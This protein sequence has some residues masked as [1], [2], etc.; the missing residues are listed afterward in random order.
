MV[1]KFLEGKQVAKLMT[2]LQAGLVV[3]GAG[4][5]DGDKD[6]DIISRGCECGGHCP[7]CRS[8]GLGCSSDD[9]DDDD[10]MGIGMGLFD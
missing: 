8:K 3:A 4:D 2:E 7:D 6:W 9:D 10:E 5:T 1:A